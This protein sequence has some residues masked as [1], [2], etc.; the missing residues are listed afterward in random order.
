MLSKWCCEF[1]YRFINI[2]IVND[3]FFY[4]FVF[5]IFNLIL[6]WGSYRNVLILVY[7]FGY[8]FFIFLVVIYVKY[9]G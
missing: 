1:F 2:Y 3:L 7:F 4:K 8:V 6:F 5:C 9:Y